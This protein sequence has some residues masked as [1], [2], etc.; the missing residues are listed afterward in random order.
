MLRCASS[1][2][3]PGKE[4]PFICIPSNKRPVQRKPLLFPT[5]DFWPETIL[6]LIRLRTRIVIVPR[7]R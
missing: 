5:T 6:S 4:D 3:N 1:V 2:G 7:S